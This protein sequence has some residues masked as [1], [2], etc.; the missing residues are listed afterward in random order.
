[1]SRV[2]KIRVS[3]PGCGTEQN[4]ELVQSINT[5]RSPALRERLLKGELNFL[6]CACGR[7]VQ[8]AGNLLFHDPAAQFFCQVVP[9]GDDAAMTRAADAFHAAGATGTLRLVPSQNALIE[10]VKIRDAGFEDWVIELAK[11]LMLASLGIRDL[12]RVV[13]F[14]RAD[15]DSLFWVMFDGSAPTG[16]S[17]PRIVYDNL[18]RMR[19]ALRPAADELQIDR[20]WAVEALRRIPVAPQ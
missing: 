5:E 12:D 19:A 20:V 1:M 8:L 4:C 18:R 6:A 15:A 13:L 9:G 16:F 17:S 3:C 2:G 11:V 14:E 7:R 10:K